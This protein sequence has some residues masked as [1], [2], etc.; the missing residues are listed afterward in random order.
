VPDA[1]VIITNP[2]PYAVALE[3][4]QGMGAPVCVAKGMGA[5]AFK[6]RDIGSEP[7][8]PV[9]GCRPLARALYASVELEE[10][11]PPEHYKAVAE[12]VGYVMRLKSKM[13]RSCSLGL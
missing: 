7:D 4:K 13:S 6:I 8:V 3:Y 5:I 12:V 10:S 9:V 1:A 11:I 2:T